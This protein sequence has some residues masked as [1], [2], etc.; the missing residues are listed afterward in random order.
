MNKQLGLMA[1]QYICVFAIILISPYT[2]RDWQEWVIIGIL[3]ILSSTAS[4]SGKLEG[5]G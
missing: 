5:R 2:L 3:A 4:Y 1:I